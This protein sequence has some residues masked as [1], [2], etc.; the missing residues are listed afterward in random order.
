MHEVIRK[1]PKKGPDVLSVY[2]CRPAVGARAFI[3]RMVNPSSES[4]AS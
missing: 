4:A 3:L 2:L 1:G